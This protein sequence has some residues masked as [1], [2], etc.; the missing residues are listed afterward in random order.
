MAKKLNKL[1]LN[2][3]FTIPKIDRT[4]QKVNIMR[5]DD[6]GNEAIICDSKGNP[7]EYIINTD[8]T[9]S[10]VN[11]GLDFMDSRGNI[12]SNNPF[13]EYKTAIRRNI[14]DYIFWMAG[15]K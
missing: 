1:V 12:I 5:I 9:L 3:L 8:G 7:K 11:H 15:F 10:G 2:P 13:I 14:P 6:N 4:G